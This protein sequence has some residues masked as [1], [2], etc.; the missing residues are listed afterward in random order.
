[1]IRFNARNAPGPETSYLYNGE[2]SIKATELRMA[3]SALVEVS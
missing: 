2:I 1:M 3:I